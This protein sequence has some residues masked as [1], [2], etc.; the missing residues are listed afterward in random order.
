MTDYD[1]FGM[2]RE[3]ATEVALPWRGEPAVRR[4]HVPT[5]GGAVSALVWGEPGTSPEYVLLHGG[6]QNAH[7]WDTVALA[8]DRPLVAI[9]LPGHGRSDWRDDHDYSPPVLAEAVA[10]AVAE[11]A[12]DAGVVVGMSL[13][14][15]TSLCLA[16]AHP[17]LVR[18][19]VV[20][21]VTP[22][23][24]HAKAEPIIAFVSGPERFANLDEILARTIQYNPTR[25][26]S[27]L[28]RGVLHNAKEEPDGSWVWRY[29]RVRSWAGKVTEAPDFARLW[30]AVDAVRAPM[31]LV[32]GGLSGVVGD[33]D[34]VELLRRQPACE[35][36]VVDG[37]GHSVQGDR[38]LELAAIL[39][40]FAKR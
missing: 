31:M 26:E 2:F 30:E 13:G 34:V 6:A 36:V 35:V 22:G 24:D 29:D 21:D 10:V 11:L 39:A 4:Q 25:S 7:T 19:L 40:R 33:E 18:K 3:N 32:R 37:A 8:L 27:S 9:D 28:R 12:P 5:P 17:E 15:L 20:V 38:P 23:T 1:E 14:G 16:A